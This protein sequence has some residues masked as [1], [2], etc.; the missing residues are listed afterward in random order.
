MSQIKVAVVGVGHMGRHH[1]R[2]YSELNQV[3][4]VAIVDTNE[5]LAKEI[6]KKYDVKYYTDYRD[7]LGRVDAVNIAVPT[8]LHYQI[9][10]DFLKCGS[11]ILLEKPMTA[12][13]KEA[14]KLIHITDTNNLILQV[15]HIERFNPAVMELKN[16]VTNPI[17]IEAHRM[18]PPTA[19][20][21]DIGVVLELMIHDL[22]IIL[23]LVDSNIKEINAMGLSIYSDFEDIAQAQILFENGC[24]ATLSA[25]RVSAEK[26]RN[27][28]ITQED[29]F[30]HLDYIDQNI[31]LRRQVSSTY[32]FDQPKAMHRR[33]FMVEQPMIG[34]EEPLR[35]QIQHFIEC[36]NENKI[37]FVSGKD[38]RKALAVA[39]EILKNMAFCSSKESKLAKELLVMAR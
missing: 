24:I 27:L 31:T 13:L 26:V 21:L 32:I 2:I 1:A 8:Y 33:E 20:N 28:E 14:D 19:R 17:F 37:P 29:A 10:R 3:E 6:S 34:K 7:I 22:D 25:S 5:M 36:I 18:G 9:A 30:L 12:N 15:G 4:L 35:L 16:F 39:M 11:N 23:S 38:G